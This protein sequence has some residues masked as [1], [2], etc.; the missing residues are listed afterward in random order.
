MN[1]ISGVS[2]KLQGRSAS[3]SSPT[4]DHRLLVTN[5]ARGSVLATC[6]EVADSGPKRNKGLLGRDGLAPGEGLWIVPCESVH[7]FFMRFP[8]DLVYLDR[9][10]RIKKVRDSVGPW[11]LS[12]CLSAHSVI[13]LPAGTIRNTQTQ[14]GDMLEFSRVELIG[15]AATPKL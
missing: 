11:R 6:L 12:A 5:P 3:Q 10:N 8:I 7:T 14:P 9:K 4:T 2:M 15:R 1:P 13:E